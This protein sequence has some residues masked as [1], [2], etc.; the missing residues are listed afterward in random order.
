MAKAR[1]SIREGYDLI[2]EVHDKGHVSL[3]EFVQGHPRPPTV[4]SRWKAVKMVDWLND[5][6]TLTTDDQDSYD[7]VEEKAEERKRRYRK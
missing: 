5:H 1:L 7:P 6:I 4:M 2:L 3:Q